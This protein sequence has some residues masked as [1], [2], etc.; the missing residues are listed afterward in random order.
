MCALTF[1]ALVGLATGCAQGVP[2]NL[3][4]PADPQIEARFRPP[5]SPLVGLKP[6]QPVEA[7]ADWGSAPPPPSPKGGGTGST[8]LEMKGMSMPGMSMPGMDMGGKR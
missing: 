8:T 7:R 1:A 4:A 2:T 5:P 3:L 6:Y